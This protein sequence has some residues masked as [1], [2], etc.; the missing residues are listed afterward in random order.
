MPSRKQKFNSEHLVYIQEKTNG[1]SDLEIKRH[2]GWSDAILKRHQ[3]SAFAD[4]HVFYNNLNELVIEFFNTSIES[5]LIKFRKD[6]I[7]GKIII[8]VI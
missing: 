7:L 2:L 3:A 8:E 1:K 4:G 6:S 5:P